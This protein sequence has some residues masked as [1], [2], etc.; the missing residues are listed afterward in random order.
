MS[1]IGQSHSSNREG[2]RQTISGLLAVFSLMIL[3]SYMVLWRESNRDYRIVVIS[4]LV[5]VVAIVF[6]PDKRG[7]LCAASGFTGI[8]W[9]LGAIA[10]RE[11]RAVLATVFFIGLPVAYILLEAWRSSRRKTRER[12]N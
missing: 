2:T 11:H 5:F 4:L 8:R 10:T 3:S 7:S 6:S 12:V 9:L 1:P